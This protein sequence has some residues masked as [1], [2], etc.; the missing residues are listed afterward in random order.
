[1]QRQLSA[2]NTIKGTSSLT[3]YTLEPTFQ[4]YLY[5]FIKKYQEMHTEQIKGMNR[6]L[7]NVARLDVEVFGNE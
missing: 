2:K 4:L 1:M 3:L 6:L 7:R 5:R